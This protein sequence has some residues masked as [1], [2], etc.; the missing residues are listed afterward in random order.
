M[1][2]KREVA[3][4]SNAVGGT[5]TLIDIAAAEVIGTL[6]VRRHEGR[7]VSRISEALH[8]DDDLLAG[9]RLYVSWR[10]RCLRRSP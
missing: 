2:C 8:A 10:R 9:P 3:F 6:G 1:R 5:V 4:V 7:R